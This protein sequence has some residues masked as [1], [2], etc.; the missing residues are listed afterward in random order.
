[1]QNI[2]IEKPYKF[3]PPHRGNW[4]PSF[5]QTFRL[6][7][8]WLRRS[9]GVV[10]H[11]CRNLNRLEASLAAGHGILLT[12][13]HSR[14]SDPIVMGFPARELRTHVYA[15]ASWHLYNQD[16][17]SAFAIQKMGGFSV[18]REGVD[19][20][21]IN[22]AINILQTAER[23]LIIF[24]EGATTRI[25]DQL[26]H[27]LDGVSFIARTA[28][29]RRLKSHA[30][31]KVVVHPVAIKYFYQGDLLEAVEPTLSSIEERLT[32]Q[33]ATELPLIQRIVRIGGALLSLK[34]IEYFGSE[35]TGSLRDRRSTLIDHL[36]NPIEQEWFSGTKEE[37]GVISR[38]KSL[39]MVIVPE[40]TRNELSREEHRRRWKQLASIYLVQQLSFYPEDYLRAP[41]SVDRVL[42][43]VERLEEDLTDVV[44][45]HPPYKVVIDVGESIEVS[46]QRDRDAETDPL[47]DR[48]R[49]DLQKMLDGLACESVIYEER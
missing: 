22:T 2:V 39:R 11:E 41:T 21:A 32:W 6:I 12:P 43:T 42:E 28:A 33:L 10:Q 36:L 5:V 7:D 29:K 35:Q 13:N 23:P 18:N 3:I 31:G 24:P 38:I 15:M 37:E 30:A 19:R 44:T 25:N 17:F 4:W 8:R 34:E 20:Q 48:I 26:Q 14:P 47:M 9:H 45:P 49:D 40:M 46:P 1:M 16:R 27:F